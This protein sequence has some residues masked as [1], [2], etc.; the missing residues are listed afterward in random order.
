MA[1][2]RDREIQETNREIYLVG[3][4]IRVIDSPFSRIKRGAKGKVIEIYGDMSVDLNC[5]VRVKFK[6]G[7]SD[8]EIVAAANRFMFT[9]HAKGEPLPDAEVVSLEDEELETFAD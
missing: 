3:D 1:I 8:M 7:G 9:K 2:I 6:V 4:T 5:L